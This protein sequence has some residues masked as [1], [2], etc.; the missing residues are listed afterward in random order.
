MIFFSICSDNL[1]QN[2]LARLHVFLPFSPR[3]W[4]LK[5][6]I[7]IYQYGNESL[8]VSPTHNTSPFPT[9]QCWVLLRE[10]T[11]NF[12]IQH[13]SGGMG[14]HL[15]D[16]REKRANNFD[17]DCLS[18]VKNDM[19]LFSNLR[20]ISLI[21]QIMHW[22]LAIICMRLY[23]CQLMLHFTSPMLN[24][25]DWSLL[26]TKCGHFKCSKCRNLLYFQSFIQVFSTK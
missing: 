3:I 23:A 4:W 13:W 12:M 10:Q 8:N 25:R 21:K 18:D 7:K 14:A 1:G 6:A 5:R 16:A 15:V 9:N 17:R 11:Q 22:N 26:L 19:T 24:L 2:Y 20:V